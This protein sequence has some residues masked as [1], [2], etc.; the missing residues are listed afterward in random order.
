LRL[1]TG[2]TTGLYQ[3][4]NIASNGDISFYEDT[5]TTAKFFWDASAESLGIGTSSP[6]AKVHSQVN[7][8]TDA[9]KIAVK[10]YNN[11]AV[12]VYANFQNATTGTGFADGFRVGIDDSENAQ[13]MNGE[14]TAMTFST[15]STERMRIDSSGNVGIGTSSPSS[16]LHVSGTYDTIF[17]GNSVQFTRAGPSYI[18]NNTAGGYTVFQ[19]AS[20]EAMRLDASGNLLVG[21]TSASGFGSTT[22]IQMLADGRILS[23]VSGDQALALSRTSSDGPIAEFYKDGTTVGSIGTNT[24]QLYI[25]YDNGSQDVGILFGNT[26]ANSRA[27]I[28]CRFDG[29]IPDG[30][31]NIGDDSGRWKDLYLSGG[32]YL[33]GTGSANKLDDYEEGTFNPFSGVSTAYSNTSIR[34]ATYT[35]IGRMVSVDVR[36]GW[37]GTDGSGSDVSLRLPFTS[38]TATGTAT[39]MT[40]AVFY[41]GSQL[42]SGAAIVTHISASSNSFSFYRTSGSTFSSVSRSSTN[43]TYD[44]V[45]SFVYYVP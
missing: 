26:T 14:N 11:Q 17:D 38:G 27:I 19:Q 2:D 24:G 39:S 20:G 10:G 36:V 7:T 44:F 43:G 35:K 41:E 13:L 16:K 30:A 8:F 4:M 23:T 40:G 21:Q 12:G 15:N 1:F 18:Q 33:G 9:D 45:C 3:R 34:N 32:V 25:G 29:S 42:F 37:T 22:G 31:I 6:S 28:P 5:G